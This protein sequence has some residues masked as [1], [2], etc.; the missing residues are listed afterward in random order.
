[1]KILDT[2]ITFENPEQQITQL[3][4]DEMLYWVV[5]IEQWREGIA[6]AIMLSNSLKER[7]E[8]KISEEENRNSSDTYFRTPTTKET[9]L[10]DRLDTYF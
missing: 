7:K 8:S 3:S 1:M 2:P 10:W 4:L 6:Y 9:I 5:E